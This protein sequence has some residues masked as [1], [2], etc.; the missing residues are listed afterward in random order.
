MFPDLN[1]FEKWSIKA[2]ELS[3]LAKIKVSDL[4]ENKAS[5]SDRK[6]GFDLAD[7]LIKYNCKDF[8]IPEQEPII[9]KPQIEVNENDYY[10]KEP[11]IQ[12]T[13]NWDPII[14]ELEKY[15][16]SATIP[17]QPIKPNPYTT[18][19]SV[20]FFIESHLS[21]VKANNGKRSF[22]PYLT[23]LQ[24]LMWYLS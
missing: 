11:K 5:Y 6:Q 23:R 21:Y 4:L 9:I 10:P 19:L 20:P 18:I 13:E 8:S 22:K 14:A 24:E 3:L 15:F 2:K 7:Y 17:T 12:K 1:A 16:N